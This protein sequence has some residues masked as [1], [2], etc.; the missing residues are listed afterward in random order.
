MWNINH[1]SRWFPPKPS[2]FFHIDLCLPSWIWV[3][4]TNS[5]TWIVR[6]FGDDFPY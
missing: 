2:R 1:K 3:N 6:P 4:Y 5:L